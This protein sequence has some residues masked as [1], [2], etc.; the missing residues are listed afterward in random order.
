MEILQCIVF[1]IAVELNSFY[2]TLANIK[3]IKIILGLS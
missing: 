2:F 3:N 1:A